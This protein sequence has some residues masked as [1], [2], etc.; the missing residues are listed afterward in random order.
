MNHLIK[1]FAFSD[2]EKK[3]TVTLSDLK[4][5]WPTNIKF[6]IFKQPVFRKFLYNKRWKRRF[7]N[8]WKSNLRYH[9]GRKKFDRAIDT[10]RILAFYNFLTTIEKHS[11]RW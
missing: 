4:I 8:N 10:H 6:G 5:D 7:K 1:A 11:R 2:V 9:Y 3:K